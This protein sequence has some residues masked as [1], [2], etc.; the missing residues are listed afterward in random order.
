MQVELVKEFLAEAAH[1]NGKGLHGHSYR[2]EIV[3]AGETDPTYGWLID[4]GDLKERFMPLYAQLDH[5]CLNDVDGL[6]DVSLAGVR[7][8]I[9]ERL[10]GVLLCLADVR[11]G[12]VGDCAFLPVVLPA[13]E[14]AGLPARLRF[15]FEAAQLLPHLPEGHPCRR[16]HGHTYRVEVGADDPGRLREPLEGVYDALDHRYLNEIPGLEAATSERL[17]AWMWEWLSEQVDD[18]RVVVVQET[19]TARCAYHGK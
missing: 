12:I 10:A 2:I 5:H 18:L 15:T 11:V 7:A 4:Y 14:A 3:A 19:A 9:R 8:W 17:C 16:L 6:A 1:E 13:D